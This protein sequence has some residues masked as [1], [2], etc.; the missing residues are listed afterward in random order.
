MIGTALVEL[1]SDIADRLNV[2]AAGRGEIE[3]MK[4][5]VAPEEVLDAIEEGAAS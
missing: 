3:E 4:R 2:P 5:Q 1:V